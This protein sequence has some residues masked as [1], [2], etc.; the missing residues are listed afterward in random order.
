LFF[1]IIFRNRALV[2]ALSVAFI[3]V[4]AFGIADLQVSTDN[5]IFYGEDNPYYQDY[6]DFESEFTSNDNILFVIAA[7][8]SITDNA[9]Y[10]TAIRWLT[11]HAGALSHVIRID[12]L[13]NYPH[14]TSEDATLIVQSILDWACPE[15]GPCTKEIESTLSDAHLLNR[16][17]S[18]DGR[19]TGVV[20]TVSLERGAVGD[21]EALQLEA[22]QLCEAFQGHFPDFE[23]YFTGGV[24]MMAAF[25]Q[26]TAEDL[27]I[28]LLMF[29]LGSIRLAS[30]IILLGLASIATT[31]G[32]AGW[33]GHTLNNATSIVP[34][35]VF[36]LVVTT[37]MHIAVHYSR[38][39]DRRADKTKAIAQARASSSSSLVPIAISATT[40]AVSLCSLW[41]VDSPPIRQL[42]FLSAIGVVIGFCLTIGILPILLVAVRNIAM[43]RLGAFVQSVVNAYA[44]RQ[45]S[46]TDLVVI[47]AVLLTLCTAGL[48]VL[49]VNDDFVEFF[50]ESVPF[51]VHTDRATELLAGPNHIEAILSNEQGSVFEPDFLSHLGELAEYLREQPAV[52]NAHSFSDVME[53]V[54]K[55][56]MDQPLAE[57]DSADELAQLFLIYELSLQIGQSNTDLTNADQDSARISVLLKETT[58]SEIQTLEQN[59]Y[60]WHASKQSPYHLTVTGENIPVAH[61]SWMNIKSMVTGIF[62]SLSFTALVIGFTFKSLRLGIVALA[63]TVF[64][65]LAGFGAW[66]WINNE[67]GL[68]ATAIIAL[69]VGVVVDD[70]AHYMY[71]FLDARNRLDMDPSSSAAYATHRA[72]AA[73][74]STSLV[75]GL[76]LSLLLLS[77]FEVNSSFGAV[78]CLIIATALAFD[79]SLLPRL[80]TW[81]VP[82]KRE[83]MESFA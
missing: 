57:I 52:A 12:S 27:G 16:L 77:S 9:K 11:Q 19:A 58:S 6:L 3:G 1:D 35:I 73:I 67:I 54:A 45:E 13:A 26:A 46:R 10:P 21:I 47:P 76:G 17:A 15:G 48:V 37:S 83:P 7:P 4:A 22:R 23:I 80:T 72:G 63:A 18:S 78:A 32:L 59:L 64:P 50:D 36:T 62:I 74:V 55:A 33:F 49:D 40:S 53:Q 75:M 43:T 71:R 56:F 30:M 20:A 69:T 31:L 2:L 60:N 68:A 41:F 51:R 29:V 28:L 5:R 34:L 61:L 70:A 79:L 82:Q 25:A 8:F 14:P 44:R 65:V 24:P 81:A 38:N 39:I 66:G 42:G